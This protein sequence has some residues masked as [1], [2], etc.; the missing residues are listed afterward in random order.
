ME[1]NNRAKDGDEKEM[2]KEIFNQYFDHARHQE[3]QRLS[4]LNYYIIVVGII[5]AVIFSQALF[6]EIKLK[7]LLLIFIMLLSVIGF[8]M[9]IV[10]RIAFLAY[11][12]KALKILNSND[13]KPFLP[14]KNVRIKKPFT[15]FELF[16]FFYGL[17]FSA[18]VA[19]TI[20]FWRGDFNLSLV[21]F[22]VIDIIAYLISR[23]INKTHKNKFTEL[24]EQI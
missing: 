17:I 13:L 4:F 5:F 6:G 20:Y 9:T 11:I 2:L 16:L 8:L 19:L 1:K 15:A 7:I 24:P 3:R 14:Y 10:W 21:I 12:S 22:V 18:T 23:L